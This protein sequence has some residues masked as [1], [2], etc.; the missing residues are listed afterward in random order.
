MRVK[1]L[2]LFV[3]GLLLP[4]LV[5]AGETWYVSDKLIITLRSGQGNQYQIIKTLPSGTPLEVLEKTET[6]YTRVRTPDGLEGWVRTQY[7]I[8]EPIA[9]VK[10]ERA[11]KKLAR[12]QARNRK[13]KEELTQLRKR[14]AELEAERK[15]LLASNQKAEAELKR[16][17]E[18]AA[19]PLL[20]DKQNRELKQQ[21]VRL[22]K[23]LQVLQQENQ[24]LKDRSQREWFIA[25]ALVLFGGLLLGLVI[26]RIR[27]RKKSSW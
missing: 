12:L 1:K 7:L 10:L 6:G 3:A 11:E 13:L 17:N 20:L 19:R 18:V 14:T 16:L 25:G 15:Q 8:P 2:P 22:E 4:L 21:N 5:V 24:H 9:A 26:P 27:W 23:E